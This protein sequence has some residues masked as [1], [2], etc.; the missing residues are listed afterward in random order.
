MSTTTPA[1][2]REAPT[3]SSEAP[4]SAFTTGRKITVAVG[5][6]VL[7][8]AGYFGVRHWNFAESHEET[9]DAQIQGHVSPVLPRVSGY[10]TRVLVSDNER[11]TAGQ[12]LAEIDAQELDLKVAAAQ[13]GLQDAIADH[14]TALARL[15]DARAAA[16]VAAA[17]AVAARVERDKA[18]S[19][20]ARDRR[21]FA[22]A[23]ITD[24]Q[25]TD[26]QA[27][28]DVAA[29][30]A[31]AAE[32]QAAAAA[33]EISVAQAGVGAAE[34]VVKER[35]SDLDYARLERSYATLTAPIDGLVSQKDVEV[36]QY[37]QSGQTLMSISADADTWIVAN[38]K[39]TQIADIHPG[40][41]AE[42][43]VDGYRGRVFRGRVD[44]LAGATGA[45]FSLLP[46]D[47]AS[48]N[49]VK[50]TQRVPVKITIDPAPGQPFLRAGLSVDVA[51]ATKQ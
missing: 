20:L 36:G 40:E 26:S 46:P 13:A 51:V 22:G 3:K 35:Q 28:A 18:A 48:G 12:P 11:V 45:R 19:D 16:S 49:F 2:A 15:E 37:V 10:V 44:S 42:F 7:A 32:R 27:A 29:A 17:Q 5:V 43:T 39:E 34:A 4:A 41:P 9:D 24:L 8:V 1:Q 6:A 38:Y 14:G 21:L 30:R 47:N 50:V 31:V 33:A 23:A 25:L